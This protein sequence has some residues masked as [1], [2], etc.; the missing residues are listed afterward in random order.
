[1]TETD[2]NLIYLQTDST[3]DTF[4]IYGCGTFHETKKVLT[5]VEAS[6][7]YVKL[8]EFLSIR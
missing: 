6:L 4:T 2:N 5:K 3:K 7:L 1:M 8:H